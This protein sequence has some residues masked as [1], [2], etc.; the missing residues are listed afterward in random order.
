MSTPIPTELRKFR[1]GFLQLAICA[2]IALLVGVLAGY[3]AIYVRF[4][5]VDLQ[6]FY[7]VILL[8]FPKL[9]L[10]YLLGMLLICLTML[11]PSGFSAAGIYGCSFWCS[12]LFIEWSD[13]AKI[14]SLRLLNLRYLR[15]Y[16]ASNRK[17]IWLPLFQSHS[18]EFENEIRKCAPPNHLILN[19]FA[20]KL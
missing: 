6:R 17:V 7:R 3:L 11:F 20:K 4:G 10:T 1:V 15:I 16:S 8:S 14:K 5:H 2:F 19:Y 9:F 18:L 13:V 12:R